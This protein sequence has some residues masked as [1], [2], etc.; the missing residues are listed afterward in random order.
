[1]D[2]KHVSRQQPRP[3][4]LS[5]LQASSCRDRL[6]SMLLL[7]SFFTRPK[8]P[9]N[10]SAG[11]QAAAAEAACR[12][13]AAAVSAAVSCAT[14]HMLPPALPIVAAPQTIPP[15]SHSPTHQ[16]RAQPLSRGP[17]SHLSRAASACCV[18]RAASQLPP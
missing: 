7:M 9:P 1:V 4:W 18:R 14:C 15:P 10:W 11:R 17:G 6:T 13:P 8:A 12:A 5:A 16:S 3:C 2:S